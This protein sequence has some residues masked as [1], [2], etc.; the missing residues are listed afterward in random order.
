LQKVKMSDF[1]FIQQ[2]GH[3]VDRDIIRQRFFESAVRSGVH[4]DRA[5]AMWQAAMRG[6]RRALEVIEDVCDIEAVSS[7]AGFGFLKWAL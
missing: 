4:P 1:R 2:D 6:E 5:S 7:T 3:S